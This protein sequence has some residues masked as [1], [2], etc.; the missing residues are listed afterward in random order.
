M[1]A[2]VRPVISSSPCRRVR[3]GESLKRVV[4]CTAENKVGCYV[5]ADDL[6]VAFAAFKRVG[7]RY[8]VI[9][10]CANDDVVI[11]AAQ[12]SPSGV[13]CK[14]AIAFLGVESTACS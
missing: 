6:I 9:S 4:A 7:A 14:T 10:T 3:R 11:R 5:A 12:G 1:S 13:P 8:R 2:S